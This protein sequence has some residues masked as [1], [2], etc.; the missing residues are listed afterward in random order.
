VSLPGSSAA[1]SKLTRVHSIRKLTAE[2]LDYQPPVRLLTLLE[3]LRPTSDPAARAVPA[4]PFRRS[5]LSELGMGLT[6]EEAAERQALLSMSEESKSTALVK[7]LKEAEG[8]ENLSTPKGFLLTGPPGT[9][10]VST[11]FLPF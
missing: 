5:P 8:L 11:L 10:V 4:W 7:V 6:E 9:S 2:L 3:A 1:D